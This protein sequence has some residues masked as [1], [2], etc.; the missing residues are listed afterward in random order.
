M[1]GLSPDAQRAIE[2]AVDRKW[3][4]YMEKDKPKMIINFFGTY[5]A[6]FCSGWFLKGFLSGGP[7]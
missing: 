4:D 5:A 1:E 7:K 2:N 6:G 3:R